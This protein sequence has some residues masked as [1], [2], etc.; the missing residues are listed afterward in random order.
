VAAEVGNAFRLAPFGTR[1]LRGIAEAVPVFAVQPHDRDLAVLP[2][3][4]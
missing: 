3:T 4:K 2:A 1:T